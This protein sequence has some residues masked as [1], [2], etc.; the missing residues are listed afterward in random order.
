MFSPFGSR[1]AKV[2][3]GPVGFIKGKSKF[4]RELALPPVA[5]DLG[6]AVP[7]MIEV[8]LAPDNQ[9][10]LMMAHAAN[11][12]AGLNEFINSLLRQERLRQG[13]PMKTGDQTPPKG[14]TL[15]PNFPTLAK[16]WFGRSKHAEP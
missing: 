5:W 4:G 15:V 7:R 12:P 3:R 2:D 14:L 6:T 9:E 8:E 1:S 13:Y 11:S 16:G 10:F